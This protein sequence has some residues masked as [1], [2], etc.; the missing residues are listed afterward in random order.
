MT[1]FPEA[2]ARRF[3]NIFVCKVCK[4]KIRAPNMKVIEGRISCRKCA[5]KKLR[6]VKKK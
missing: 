6:T 2:E 5:N 3:H 1:K 4:S